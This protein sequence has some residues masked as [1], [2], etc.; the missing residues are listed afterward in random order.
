MS[1]P[2]WGPPLLSLRGASPE[3][4]VSRHV[5]TP[6]EGLFGPSASSWAVSS[7]ALEQ[8]CSGAG[9]G[10]PSATPGNVMHK[11]CPTKCVCKEPTASKP[12]RPC[13]SVEKAGSCPGVSGGLSRGLSRERPRLSQMDRLFAVP[14]AHHS[15]E[16]RRGS[17]R[18]S[19]WPGGR[20]AGFE[21]GLL[22]GEGQSSPHQ[23]PKEA[24]SRL[25]SR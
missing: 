4:S 6:Q 10:L 23:G 5:Q 25:T 17:A 21:L 9:E 7:A 2:P 22:P 18:P 12:P 13:A 20:C 14:A 3:L 19:A 8:G 15:G 11:S 16:V 1:P 24:G